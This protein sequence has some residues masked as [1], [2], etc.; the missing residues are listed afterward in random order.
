ML[1]SVLHLQFPK[2]LLLLLLGLLLLL[3]QN[4]CTL[5]LF[6]NSFFTLKFSDSFLVD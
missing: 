2:I 1:S 5:E 4:L 3:K 6:Y